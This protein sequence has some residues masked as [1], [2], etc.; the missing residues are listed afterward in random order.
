MSPRQ[1]L[2]GRLHQMTREVST[3]F[4]SAAHTVTYN[5]VGAAQSKVLVEKLGEEV[6]FYEQK[7]TPFGLHASPEGWGKSWDSYSIASDSLWL[8]FPMEVA[9]ACIM[10][11]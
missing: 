5:D 4:T 3:S 8:P 2:R 10:C 7:Q 11:F 6:I 9:L 1:R